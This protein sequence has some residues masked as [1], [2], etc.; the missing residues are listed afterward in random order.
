M[1]SDEE[2]AICLVRGEE[3]DEIRTYRYTYTEWTTQVADA[4]MRPVFKY[5][6]AF[7]ETLPDPVALHEEDFDT[8]EYMDYFGC[9]ALEATK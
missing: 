6:D 1:I 9:T 3:L 5:Q 7:K 2:G 8:Y 4:L